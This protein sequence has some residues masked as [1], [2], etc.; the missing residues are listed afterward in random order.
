MTKFLVIPLNGRIDK[1]KLKCNATDKSR[2]T[3]DAIPLEIR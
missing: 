1:L 2:R 3:G